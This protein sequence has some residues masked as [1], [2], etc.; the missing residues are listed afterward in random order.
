MPEPMRWFPFYPDRF[1]TSKRVRRMDAQRV[2]VYWLLLIE[3]WDNGAI[4]DNDED[5]ALVGRTDVGVVREVLAACFKRTRKGWINETLEEVRAEQEAKLRRLKVAGTAGA[6]ARWN[7]GRNSKRMASP[8][9]PQSDPNGI[10]G[11]KKRVEEKRESTASARASG[12]RWRF[13]PN[14]WKPTEKHAALAKQLHV[15]LAAE[16]ARFR[17]HEFKDPKSDADRAFSRWLRTAPQY[18]NGASRNGRHAPPDT[19]VVRRFEPPPPLAEIPPADPQVAAAGIQL[20]KK[21]IAAVTMPVNAT[22][23]D[24]AVVEARE[25]AKERNLRALAA[26]KAKP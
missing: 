21:A 5:L 15:D 20:V 22:V 23:E 3:Q 8:M 19:G 10:R 25:A 1:L 6:A 26:L 12:R 11:E 18:V 24:D 9:R 4:G 14:D 16:E 7:K 13:V 2:G 17:D